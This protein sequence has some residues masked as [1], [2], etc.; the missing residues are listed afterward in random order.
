VKT[1]TSGSGSNKKDIGTCVRRKWVTETT[2]ETKYKFT[3]WRYQE[4]P[5]DTSNFKNFTGTEIVTS[6]GSD[7]LVDQSGAYDPVRLAKM[8]RGTAPDGKRVTGTI[9]T[10]TYTWNGCIEERQSEDPTATFSFSPISEDAYDLQFDTPAETDETRWHPMWSN[11]EYN[12]TNYTSEDSTSS[13]SP[14]SG[15]CPAKMMLFKDVTLSDDPNDIPGWLTTY[16]GTLGASGY[17]YHDIGM[18]WGGR[19]TSPTGL[20]SDNVNLDSDKISVS[21]HIIFMTD[22]ILQPEKDQYSAYGIE[23]LDSRIA[24]HDK[25][26]QIYARHMARFTAMCNA[27]KAQGT[28]IWVV[29]FGTSMTNELKNCASDGRAYYSSNTTALR[30]TFK[31]IAA[32][33]A[34]LRLG[35]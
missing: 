10:S 1:G 4:T 6:V 23:D 8:Y 3:T 21:K 22:G 2:Y 30:S 13:K 20:F 14:I 7:A 16:L 19:L 25:V 35:S 33:V 12:R 9:G 17:T 32:Q 5:I 34:D 24:P 26:D 31:F 18:I 27:I 28:S 11:V 29:A 15:Y